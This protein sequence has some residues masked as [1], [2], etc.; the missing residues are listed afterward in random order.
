M[1]NGSGTIMPMMTR[2]AMTT[3]TRKVSRRGVLK[4]IKASEL[5]AAL[6]PY[7]TRAQQPEPMLRLIK[8]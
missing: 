3:E 2:M 6:A 5:H 8:G 1:K 4:S 7:L